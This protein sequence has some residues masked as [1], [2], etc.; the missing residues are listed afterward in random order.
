MEFTETSEVDPSGDGKH[1][2]PVLLGSQLPSMT[3][4]ANPSSHLCLPAT[5]QHIPPDESGYAL[6][7]QPISQL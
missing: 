5:P 1:M 2:A 6:E 3:D 7:M 4:L